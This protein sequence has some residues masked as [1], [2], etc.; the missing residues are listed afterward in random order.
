MVKSNDRQYNLDLLKALAI[1]CMVICHAVI[2]FGQYRPEF[3]SEFLYFFGDC[4]LG[5]Y[6][7]VAHGFMF[8]MG[9][10]VIYSRK[11]NPGDLIRRGVN[12]LLLGYVFNFFR[13]G[14]YYMTESLIK[15]NFSERTL[16]ALF[17]GDILHFAGL[18]LIVTGIFKKLKLKGTEILFIGLILSMIGTVASGVDTHNYVLNMVVGLIL[19]TPPTQGTSTFAFCNWYLFVAV[20]L[21]FGKLLQETID[22]DALY[23]RLLIISGIILAIYIASTCVCGWFF[24]CKNHAYYDAS[25]L[26]ALGLLAID[27]FILSIFHFLLKKVDASK[28]RRSIEMSKNINTIFCIHWYIIGALEF[29]LCHLLNLKIMTNYV[30]IYTIGIVL[31]VVSFLLARFYKSLKA[32][33]MAVQ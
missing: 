18:A 22:K 13:H 29:F 14:I 33:Y 6:I 17:R 28:F 16:L 25:P 12:I 9:V 31:V 21:M 8:A 26:E 5:A 15:G 24:L 3:R 7:V 27:F 20:G 32:K 1:V 19:Y 2:T 30:V 4:I 10:G 23:K 11:N